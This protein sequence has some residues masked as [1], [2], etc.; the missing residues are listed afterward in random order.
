MPK[1]FL[2]RTNDKKTIDVIVDF[3]SYLNNEKHKGKEIDYELSIKRVRPIRSLDHNRYYWAIL[4]SIAVVTGYTSDD[5]HEMFKKKFN[6]KYVID[7]LVGHTTTNLDSAEFNIY[8]KQVKT[9]AEQVLNVRIPD[10]SDKDYL[11]W[12]KVAKEQYNEMIESI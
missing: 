11:I 2:F 10:M 8:V 7:E 6:S 12:A 3:F 1:T 4:N 5:L 9:Y